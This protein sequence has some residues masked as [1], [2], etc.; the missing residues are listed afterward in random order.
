MY[1]CM[2]SVQYVCMYV[3]ASIAF[4]KAPKACCSAPQS[5]VDFLVLWLL[6]ANSVS[7]LFSGKVEDVHATMFLLRDKAYA[8]T[9]WH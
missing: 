9:H 7:V 3:S 6:N 8:Y 5:F 1:E 4:L 2:Y